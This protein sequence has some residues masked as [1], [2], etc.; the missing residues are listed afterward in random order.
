MSILHTLGGRGDGGAETY[1]TKLVAALHRTESQY[2]VIGRHDGRLK[3][4]EQH[5]ILCRTLPF[6]GPVDIYSSTR[7]RMLG[8][9]WQPRAMVAWMRR[10]AQHTPKG[11][12]ARIGRLGGYYKLS[13]F[14]GFDGL[15]A[16][17]RDIQ[18][19]LIQEGVPA[20]RTHYIPNF[21]HLDELPPERRSA[22]NTPEDAPLLLAPGRLHDA[23]AHDVAIIALKQIPDAHLWIVGT[24]PLEA[25][26]KTLAE[27]KG[28]S[29]RVHFLGWRSDM[30]ALYGAADA[31]VFPSRYEPLG[32]VV[33]EAWMAGKP[34]IAAKSVGP[35]N[36]IMHGDDGL[37]FRIDDADELAAL[38]R[39]LIKSKNMQ[40]TLAASG[41]VRAQDHTAAR[42]TQE[43]FALFDRLTKAE[44]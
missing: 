32:N 7:L 2:A 11:P 1:F 4:L 20:N 18:D 14:Q 21:A 12:W 28:V 26:L 6:G 44:V 38:T 9:S 34:I 3:A 29:D 31:V 13:S 24:G 42:V 41:R 30:G 40:Q 17:T 5:N 10:A 36:L 8:R 15:I 39:Q 33:I 35:R 25:Q 27:T 19:Y 23:K 16:N 22:H 37:L 43:W